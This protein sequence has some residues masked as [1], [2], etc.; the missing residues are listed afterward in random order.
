MAAGVTSLVELLP[1]GNVIKTPWNDPVV[2]DYENLSRP[3]QLQWAR[4]AVEGLQLLYAFDILHCDVGP[5]NFLLDASL[6][7]KIAKFSGSSIS[8]SFASVCPRSRYRSPNPEWRPGK[9][10]N[11]NEDLFA[12]YSVLYFFFTGKVPF[13]K[14]E[15]DEVAKNYKTGVF[16]HLSE[17]LCS[18]IMTLCWQQLN[19]YMRQLSDFVS[20]E[21]YSLMCHTARLL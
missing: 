11:L 20:M 7:L 2:G 21:K 15:G 6:N 3:L 4:Q 5:H 10:P 9:P 19:R 8:G 16:P 13:S 12:L 1:N 18:D 17:V 14:L